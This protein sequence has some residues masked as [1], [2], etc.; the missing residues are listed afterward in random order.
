MLVEIVS[1]LAMPFRVKRGVTSLLSR[2][3][4]N[5]E[6][7]SRLQP[8]NNERLNLR[9][10]I[11]SA[12]ARLD[13]KAGGFWLRG[14]TA[15]FDLRVTHVNSKSNQGELTANIFKEQEN[16]TKRKNQQRVLDVG[17]AHLQPLLLALMVVWA[18]NAKCF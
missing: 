9:S 6:V 8:L 10:A 4:N 5:V 16:E 1:Q 3:C 14:V 18:A 2:V 17:W 12:E 7:E 11:T 13:M 15:F